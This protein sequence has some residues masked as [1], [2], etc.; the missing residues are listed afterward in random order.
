[1]REHIFKRFQ[2]NSAGLCPWKHGANG[3]ASN[4]KQ[5]TE[6]KIHSEVQLSLGHSEYE[7]FE[8]N[9]R[10]SNYAAKHLKLGKKGRRQYVYLWFITK[11]ED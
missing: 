8:R 2:E 9:S 4:R 10:N 11:S 5:D 3:S 6:G 1:M 7:K